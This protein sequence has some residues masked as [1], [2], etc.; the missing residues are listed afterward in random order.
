M[1]R[2]SMFEFAGGETAFL[3]LAAAHHQRC[4]RDPV[5][6]HAFSHPGNPRHV[7][8]LANY[9]GVLRSWPQEP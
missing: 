1:A 8:R 5:L 3:A 2:P 7:Q 9:W 6:N 4:L